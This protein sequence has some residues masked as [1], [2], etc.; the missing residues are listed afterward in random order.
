MHSVVSTLFAG[1][2]ITF[3]KVCSGCGSAS[4]ICRCAK[5][6]SERRLLTVPE[7]IKS[8]IGRYLRTDLYERQGLK[9]INNTPEEI[10]ALAVDRGVSASTQNQALAALVFLYR[11]VLQI[12][13]PL[14]DP[15]LLSVT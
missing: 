9:V 7:I 10:T 2:H 15:L 3:H 11:E 1:S 4:R 12:D 14:L 6:R 13:L 8:G 5:L